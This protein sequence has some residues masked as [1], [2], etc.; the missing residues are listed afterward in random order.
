MFPGQTYAPIASLTTSVP[1]LAC[2]GLTKRF[3]V[4]GWRLGWIVVYD[5][6]QVREQS[7]SNL[8]SKVFEQEVRQGLLRMSQRIIG[9]NTLVQ[10]ALPTILASTPKSFF[11]QTIS[12]IENNAKLAFRKL[13][14][15][16]G[17]TPIMPQGAMY[18]MVKMDRRM[19]PRIATDLQFVEQLMAEQSVF[20]LPG[21]CFNCPDYVRIVLTVPRE[22]LIEACHRWGLGPRT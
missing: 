14:V 22:L 12:V 10:G 19:F 3:L 7:L 11:D 20:C 15:V 21:R 18:M 5:R 2:G 4:P 13:R 17:L 16:P 6:G 8:V 1:V 9:S